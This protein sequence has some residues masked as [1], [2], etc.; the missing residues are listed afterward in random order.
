MSS[1]SQP[2]RRELSFFDVVIAG[3]GMITGAGIFAVLGTAPSDIT[4]SPRGDGNDDD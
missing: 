3:I 4:D 1:P 2:L